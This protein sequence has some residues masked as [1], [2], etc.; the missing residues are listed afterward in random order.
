MTSE[1][2]GFR[3][4]AFADNTK[5]TYSSQLRS[6]LQFCQALDIVPVPVTDDVV[7]KYAAYLARRLKPSSIKQYINVIR[8]L[9]AECKF[10]NPCQSW[11]VKSTVKG[12]ERILGNPINRKTPVLPPLLM[13]MRSDLQLSQ[14]LDA[15]FWAAALVLFFGTFRR[16]NLLPNNIVDIS[17]Q[18]K[19]SDFVFKGTDIVLHVS[20]S[21]T[22]Q[23]K[24]RVFD[25]LL[26][27]IDHQLCPV[28]A[29]KHAFALCPLPSSSLA[30]VQDFKGT[31][32]TGSVFNNFFKGVLKNCGVDPATYSSHSFRRGSA[33]W[34]LQCGIPG[35][36][37]K[38]L[39]DW[40]SDIYLSYVDQVPMSTLNHYR[41][42]FS[43]LLPRSS[44]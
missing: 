8:L 33:T 39:G 22:I 9:H 18:F 17:K 4:A 29:V 7:A 42:Q 26:Q 31:P 14:P 38:L 34:A 28:T 43:S 6:Y 24:E 25:V 13:K 5:R 11:Y 41:S 40:K 32:L 20:W 16:S 15:M 30:F 36:V 27:K 23:S 19:R 21:K 12:I 3:S 37:V 10:E 44:S 1:V 35:E 2:A